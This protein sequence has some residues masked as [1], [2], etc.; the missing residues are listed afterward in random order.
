[1]VEFKRIIGDALA[2]E[3]GLIDGL[4][5][6]DGAGPGTLVLQP[7]VTDVEISASSENRSEDGRELPE[8]K[9]GTVVFDLIDGETGEIQARFGERRRCRPPEGAGAETGAWPYLSIWAESVAADLSAEL[10]RVGAEHT[11]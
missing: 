9:E 5:Q 3:L 10:E 11:G 6:A 2:S 8:F 7:V 4:E 1:V